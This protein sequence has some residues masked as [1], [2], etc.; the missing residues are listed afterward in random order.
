MIAEAEQQN[1]TEASF[2]GAAASA[3]IKNCALQLGFQKVGIVRVEA[4]NDEAAYLQRWLVRGF[5]GEMKWMEREP[6][7]RTDPRRIFPGACSV[8]VV[9]LNY[10]ARHQRG[11][12]GG[13]DRRDA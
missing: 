4:L 6:E 3:L 12:T 10:N 5:H 9:A 8:V 11:S 2:D 1:S 13:V 7:R